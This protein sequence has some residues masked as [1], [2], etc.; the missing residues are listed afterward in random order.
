MKTSTN[1]IIY[2]SLISNDIRVSCYTLG[3]KSSG[4]FFFSFYKPKD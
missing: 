3:E 2:V 1:M 4:V